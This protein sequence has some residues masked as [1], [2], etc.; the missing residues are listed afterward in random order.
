[1]LLVWIFCYNRIGNRIAKSCAFIVGAVISLLPVL[2]FFVHA[3]RQVW[4]NLF[5]FHLSYRQADWRGATQHDI[6]TLTSWINNAPD[7]GLILLAL[8]GALFLIGKREWERGRR[9]EFFLCAGLALAMGIQNSFAHPTFRQYFVV[10][11]PFLAILAGLGLYAIALRMGYQAKPLRLVLALTLLL[12]L[13]MARSIYVVSEEHWEDWHDYEE[14][15]R[16][17]NEV[18]PP[19]ARLFADLE[20]VYFLTRREP[21]PGMEYHDSRRVDLSPALNSLLH[22]VPQAE[23][24]RQIKAGLYHTV[25]MC[26]K[27]WIDRLELDDRYAQNNEFLSD[28][29]CSVFWEWSPGSGTTSDNEK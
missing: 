21:P 18:T 7:L 8:A 12:C 13:Q 17:A 11:V 26:D 25:V 28:N 19:Q 9:A 2:W 4:Y 1:V 16:K 29:S 24:D 10:L 3:P 14:I 20:V 5:Q 15:A 23:L 27:D 6:D 22:I